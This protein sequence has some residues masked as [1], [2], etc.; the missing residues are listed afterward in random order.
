MDEPDPHWLTIAVIGA[1]LLGGAIGVVV[2]SF[3]PQ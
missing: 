1:C 3:L 2:S